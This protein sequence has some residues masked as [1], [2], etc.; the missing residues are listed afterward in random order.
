MY[1]IRLIVLSLIITLSIS[2]C[3][4]ATAPTATP[5]PPTDEPPPTPT[6]ESVEPTA[7]PIEEASS[8]TDIEIEPVEPV[9]E[10]LAIDIPAN[11]NIP[12][13]T[14]DEWQKGLAEAQLTLIEYGD[15]Q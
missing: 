12:E 3:G 10:C 7:T 15:F 6:S 13:V 9:A 14:S 2:A 4:G 1:P 11:P 5:S 8:E